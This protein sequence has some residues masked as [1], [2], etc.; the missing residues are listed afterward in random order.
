[1]AGMMPIDLGLSA[2]EINQDIQVTPT[3]DGRR[4]ELM[5]IGAEGDTVAAAWEKLDKLPG[6]SRLA[7]VKQ[8]A[9][10]LADVGPEAGNAP[11]IVAQQYGKGRTL[12]IAF[13]T[14]WRWVLSP[15]DTAEMQRRFWRQVALYLAAPKGSAWIETD[16]TRYDLRELVGNNEPV[17]VTA[18]LEDSSGT[19]VISPRP[20]VEL[21]APDGTAR[22]IPLAADP[23]SR[24]FTA[25]IPASQLSPT[26]QRPYVLKLKATVDG[27]E[28]SAQHSFEVAYRDLDSRDVEADLETLRV[29]AA[30]T[31]GS[32]RRA[33][34]FEALIRQLYIDAA[35]IKKLVTE[36]RDL[37][38]SLRWPAIIIIILL[39][40]VEWA[41]RKRRGLV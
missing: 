26:A 1:V 4:S 33:N 11:L 3:A 16:K 6:A 24:R 32:F 31:R 27:K 38:A 5:R 22:G 39:L 29:L 13:D 21:I 41:I 18:G 12:A 9:E 36:R 34:E 25:R 7:G 19:P 37:T 40:C 10:V 30:R 17:V 28:L 8:G 15:K 23:E 20:D 2:G 14:T 35:P